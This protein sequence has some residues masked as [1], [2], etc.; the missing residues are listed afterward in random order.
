[1]KGVGIMLK[2]IT[3]PIII[4]D[5]EPSKCGAGCQYWDSY[6]WICNLYNVG[7][8]KPLQRCKQCLKEA[9]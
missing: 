9:K 7:V 8:D 2:H 6:N 3:V 4:D 1:M 5:H